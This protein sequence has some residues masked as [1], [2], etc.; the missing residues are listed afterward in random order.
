MRESKEWGAYRG[1]AVEPLIREAIA[2]LLPDA[3]FGDARFVG[4][5]WTRKNTPEVDLVGIPSAK[6]KRVSFVGSIKWKDEAPFDDHDVRALS[7]VATAVPG[8]DA[9]TL[10][11][12]VARSR[13]D[14]KGL[15][16]GLLPEDLTAAWQ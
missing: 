13:V 6:P 12:G 7:S 3:R 2:R 10:L 1:R 9:K 15:D 4:G 11:V 5:Y 16:I 14:A 8:T